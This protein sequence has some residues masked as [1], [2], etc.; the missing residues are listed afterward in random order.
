MAVEQAFI[1]LKSKAFAQSGYYIMRHENLYMIIDC[2]SAKKNVPAGHK[3]NGRLSFELFAYDKSFIVDPGTYVYTS[4]SKWRNS[5]RS[6]AFHNTAVVDGKEQNEFFFPFVF[7][8]TT[9][10]KVL[11]WTVT[12]EYDIL[13]AEH[14]GY[15][16]LIHQRIIFFNK[17]EK[18]WI[19]KDQ[20]DGTG[21]HLLE[22]FFHFST[23][24][25]T[26]TSKDEFMI[27]TEMQGANL[28]IF[29]LEEDNVSLD[30]NDSW[31]SPSYGIKEKAKVI[32]YSK[33]TKLP[34]TF[35]T[36]LYPY[37]NEMPSRE[38]LKNILINNPL[39]NRLQHE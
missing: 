31:V 3:H 6:T 22:I 28:V 27:N 5:F 30:L 4:D 10:V 35:T 7:I 17:N 13:I 11:N 38:S 1:K 14:D 26:K 12:E 32:K 18:Y 21:E 24:E 37:K 34:E 8:D 36:L 15:K 39:W 19:I 16:P 9:N 2:F 25:V 23:L 33:N 29:S 20:I